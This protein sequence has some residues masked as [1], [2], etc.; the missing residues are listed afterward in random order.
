MWDSHNLDNGP[1]LLLSN[2][3]CINCLHIGPLLILPDHI[4]IDIQ[5]PEPEAILQLHIVD[6]LP[7]PHV[8]L[9]NAGDV[10]VS[11][12]LAGVGQHGF[13]GE[14]LVDELVD[15]PV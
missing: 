6:R 11:L 7:V 1:E 5:I 15:V 10:G 14:L 4:L 2:D 9:H 12:V 13:R 3:N 8:C